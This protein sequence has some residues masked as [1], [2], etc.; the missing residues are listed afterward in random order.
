MIYAGNAESSYIHM[1]PAERMLH[2][3]HE[4]VGSPDNVRVATPQ[5]ISEY[6]A[7]RTQLSSDQGAKIS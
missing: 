1:I 6:E 7:R 4:I 2:D 3:I 5:D